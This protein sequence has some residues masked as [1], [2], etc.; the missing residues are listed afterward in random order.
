MNI[1]IKKIRF[2]TAFCLVIVSLECIVS[3]GAIFSG[4]MYRGFEKDKAVLQLEVIKA[5][6]AEYY[7]RITDN[8]DSLAKANFYSQFQLRRKPILV[9]GGIL[10]FIFSVNFLYLSSILHGQEAL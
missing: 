8:N 1:D 6:D 5:N 4:L 3:V 2:L 9:T 7:K 10:I